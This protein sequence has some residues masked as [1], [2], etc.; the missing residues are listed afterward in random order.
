[1]TYQVPDAPW[2]R[3]AERDG[4]PTA[5]AV[6]CPV[7]GA[8]CE[9]VYWSHTNWKEIIACNKCLR[10]QDAYEWIEEQKGD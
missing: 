9:T 1:V 3:E 7:C 6:V 2:I 10:E 5:D 4:Y 8:N